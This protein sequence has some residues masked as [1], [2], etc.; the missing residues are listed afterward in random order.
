[1]IKAK[2]EY[3]LPALEPVVKAVRDAQ[4]KALRPVCRNLRNKIRAEL[5][6]DSGALKYGMDYKVGAKGGK[7]YGV[8]GVKARYVRKG[9]QPILYYRK[10]ALDAMTNNFDRRLVQ[11]V[12]S[13]IESEVKATFK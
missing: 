11:E 7:A 12:L 10:T 13:D 9:K 6:K 5:P 4:K 8:V 1:M 2:F 3:K